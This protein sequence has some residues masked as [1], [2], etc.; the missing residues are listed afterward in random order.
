MDSETGGGH[1]FPVKRALAVLTVVCL[2]ESVVLWATQSS[3]TD[4]LVTVRR[5]IDSNESFISPSVAL[6]E[7]AKDAPDDFDHVQLEL[8]WFYPNGRGTSERLPIWNA[9]FEGVVASP[10][11]SGPAPP[12]DAD[13]AEWRRQHPVMCMDRVSVAI[14][15]RSGDFVVGSMGGSQIPCK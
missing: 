10:P 2:A 4:E 13:Q 6:E 7:A 9:S 12:I 11:S 5:T 3:V 8:R 1:N 14:D 15:A